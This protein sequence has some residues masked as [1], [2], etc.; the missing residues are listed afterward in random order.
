[1]HSLWNSKLTNINL[2]QPLYI[3]QGYLVFWKKKKKKKK[4]TKEKEAIIIIDF[5]IK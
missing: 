3:S 1:M 4:N 2:N 5:V